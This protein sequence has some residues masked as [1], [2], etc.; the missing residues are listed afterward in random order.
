LEDAVINKEIRAAIEH[1]RG[2]QDDVAHE[3]SATLLI[4][5]YEAM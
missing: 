5:N 4:H 1:S 2:F 3:K